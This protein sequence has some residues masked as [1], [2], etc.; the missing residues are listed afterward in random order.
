MIEDFIEAR[1]QKI[2][3]N[4]EP[5]RVLRYGPDRDKGKT[6]YPLVTF[7]RIR[8]DIDYTRAAPDFTYFEPSVETETIQLEDWQARGGEK[9][10]TGP[11]SYAVKKYPI[12]VNLFYYLNSFSSDKDQSDFLQF[13]IMQAFPPAYMPEIS[14][15]NPMFSL[16]QMDSHDDMAIPLFEAGGVLSVEGVW[17]ERLSNETVAPIK[18]INWEVNTFT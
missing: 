8:Y 15:Q 4:N 2:I 10:R 6:R 12:P 14:G 18:T 17:M 13:H 11:V 1:L 7:E 16:S 5:L 3:H 9:E